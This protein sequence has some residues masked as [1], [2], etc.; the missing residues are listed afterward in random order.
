MKESN[1]FDVIIIGGSYAGLSAAMALGRS[2]RNVL[3]LD[4]GNPCNKQ[5]PRSHNFI[6]WDGAPPALVSAKA[7]EQVLYYPTIKFYEGTANE[8]HK[9]DY[10]FEII[11]IQGEK[12]KSKKILFATG[13][14]DIMPDIE[15]FSECWGISILH[16][17]YCHGYEEKGKPTAIFANREHAFHLCLVLSN[18]TKELSLFTNGKSLLTDAQTFKLKEHNIEI[19]EKKIKLIKHS[20]GQIET[21]LFEDGQE[22]NFP[23]MYAK[24]PFRQQCDLAEK[25]GCE[26]TEDGFIRVDDAKKTTV[27]GIFAAGDNSSVSRTISKSISAGTIAGM[28]LNGEM[29]L[30]SF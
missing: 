27:H 4:N 9:S 11:T 16:C 24:I 28:M 23:V 2:L 8:I 15:G 30:E 5:A 19:I 14:T 10:G 20:K 12:F 29:A 22:Q 6:T 1:D 26:I 21:V 7:K 18:L 25:I 13:V 17:P 3:I